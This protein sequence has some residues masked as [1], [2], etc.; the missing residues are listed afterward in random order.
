MKQFNYSSEIREILIK[1]WEISKQKKQLI[2]PE[3]VAYSI[4]EYY[5]NNKGNEDKV[6]ENE[7]N[8][9]SSTD[10]QKLKGVLKEFID[11]SKNKKDAS[12]FNLGWWE[13]DSVLISDDLCSI[14]LDLP[15]WA[16]KDKDKDDDYIELT[17][18][19]LLHSIAMKNSPIGNLLFDLKIK[20]FNVDR[21][22]DGIF[23]NL[24]ALKGKGLILSGDGKSS[25]KA[26]D[27][28]KSFFDM[29]TGSKGVLKEKEIEFNAGEVDEMDD[30]E[31]DEDDE[32]ENVFDSDKKALNPRE[33][34]PES[35]T[36][37]LDQ[38]ALDMTKRA[39]EGGYDPLVGRD[40]ELEQIIEILSC[41][42]KSN[43][44]LLGDPGCG[45]TAIVEG[46]AQRI[47]NKTVPLNIQGKRVL[48]LNLNDLI[49]GTKHRGDLEERMK[50]TLQELTQHSK[51]I[52]LFLDECHTALGSTS[53]SSSEIANILKPY[54]SRGEFQ[55]IG[56][57]T[58]D[59]YRKHIEKDKAIVRR[60]QNI[61]I[62]EVSSEETLKILKGIKE[63]YENFHNVKISDEVL[64]KIV[65]WSGRYVYDRYFPDKAIDVLD[66]S[67]SCAKL[68]NLEKLGV[69]DKLRKLN[70]DLIWSREKKKSLVLTQ[71]FEDAAKERDKEK[72]LKRQIDEISDVSKIVPEITVDDVARVVQ[73]I[74][75]VPIDQISSTDM[76][77]LKIM[78][79]ELSS[80]VIGQDEA[81]KEVVLSLQRN[82]L[83]LR[84]ENKPIAS[85]LFVGQT[86]C[87]KTYIS[88]M[89]AELF[90]GSSTS[91]I[92]IDMGNYT[93]QNAV[94]GLLGSPASYVGYDDEPALFAVKR[95]R[96][97]V[98]LF[99]EIEKASQSILNSV[100]LSILDEGYVT[101]ANGTR[102]SFKDCIVVFTGNIG[103]KELS[104]KGGGIG[105]SRND[106]TNKN[107]V[108]SV[109]G[110]AV[111]NQFT[112]EFLNRLS[113]VVIFNPLGREELRKIFDLELE[114]LSCRLKKQ[115]YTLK[116]DEKVK[117]K[118]IDDCD[119]KYGARDLQR[120]IT[121][122]VETEICEA[123]L[124]DNIDITKKNITVTE[125]DVVFCD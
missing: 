40:S 52:I 9:L 124:K 117:E 87:G 1:S 3:I 78:K 123:M 55:C 103:T 95:R 44:M 107:L 11:L 82:I 105:F 80:K 19:L 100:F 50:M 38:F 69:S 34:S 67:S 27:V 72:E 62:D 99:D 75:R 31:D 93:E 16:D 24:E 81:I 60:F 20:L 89:I 8:K 92:K 21:V 10:K 118:I 113:K 90:M 54:L 97:A 28:I 121:K 45:K 125:S 61:M 18:G 32:E 94:T 86:G 59:E 101:L 84:D 29:I 71:S 53:Q 33:V 91:L 30:D 109:I 5:L 88:K 116:V 98:V 13:K 76:G 122:Y 12:Y 42:K 108:E 51:E 7:I 17:A 115:G 114:K 15:N 14:F 110:K 63:K 111:N 65:E 58:L 35:K 68:S 36:P 47:V 83:G 4:V 77:K 37:T 112:P 41:R 106:E 102:V 73:K 56:S 46:L 64:E 25:A 66:L 26:E 57:T 43:A 39:A 120:G 104:L 22:V 79:D 49:A 6:L 119:L 74:S 85:F 96:N 70:D 23:D 48:S 2:T